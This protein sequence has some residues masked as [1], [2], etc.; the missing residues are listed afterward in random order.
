MYGEESELDLEGAEKLHPEYGTEP[1][2]WYKN[3]PKKFIAGTVYD[4]K[5]KE[6][7]EGAAVTIEGDAGSFAATTDDFGDF[8]VDKLP[9][10]DWKVTISHGGVSKVLEVST[11]EKDIGL[12]DIALE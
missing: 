8:W 3:L 9:E 10:A 1:R 5:V 6:V 7:V 11:K 4:P 2:V 12:G